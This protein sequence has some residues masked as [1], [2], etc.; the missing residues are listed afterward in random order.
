MTS[1]NGIL[2]DNPAGLRELIKGVIARAAI[3]AAA[4]DRAAAAWLCHPETEQVWLSAVDLDARAVVSW[5][6]AGCKISDKRY[7]GH[8]LGLSREDGRANQ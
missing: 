3:D 5:V 1:R 2:F 8:K 6:N 7:T 4:G